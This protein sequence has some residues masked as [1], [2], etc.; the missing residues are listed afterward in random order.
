M[1]LKINNLQFSSSF[2]FSF[3]LEVMFVLLICYCLCFK[4]ILPGLNFLVLNLINCFFENLVIF[5]YISHLVFIMW[6]NWI[7]IIKNDSQAKDWWRPRYHYYSHCNYQRL[8][9]F[10]HNVMMITNNWLSYLLVMLMWVQL[11]LV[12]TIL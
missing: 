1:L 11:L 2:Y 9:M 5:C 3:N 12:T 4:E 7:T 10:S 8:N 6:S